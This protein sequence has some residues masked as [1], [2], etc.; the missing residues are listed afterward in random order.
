MGSR[1]GNEAGNE[2]RGLMCIHVSTRR[3]TAL[4][5][6]TCST[7]SL[8]LTGIFDGEDDTSMLLEVLQ[9]VFHLQTAQVPWGIRLKDTQQRQLSRSL[10]NLPLPAHCMSWAQGMQRTCLFSSWKV[11][12]TRSPTPNSS[13]ISASSCA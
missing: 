11:S 13:S 2:A 10:P 8:P 1:P 5:I 7:C 12:E 4:V 3:T 9:L 6:Y